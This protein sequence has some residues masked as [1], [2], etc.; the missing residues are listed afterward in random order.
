MRLWPQDF[1][2]G[3][4]AM[5]AKARTAVAALAAFASGAMTHPST[6]ALAHAGP[7]YHVALSHR[8]RLRM[9]QRREH[10]VR[11]YAPPRVN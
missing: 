8:R 5:I 7:G 1:C 10:G 3:E 11:H 2:V 9:Q 6:T 4:P